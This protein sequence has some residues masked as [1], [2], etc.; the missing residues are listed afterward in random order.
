MERENDC[1]ACESSDRGGRVTLR[2]KCH[3]KQPASGLAAGVERINDM[4]RAGK[5]DPDRL[6]A[7]VAESAEPEFLTTA[8]AAALARVTVPT[9]QKWIRA[10]IVPVGRIG[11]RYRIHRGDFIRFIKE[12]R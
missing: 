10:G 3:S 7:Y 2:P 12:G 9:L 4:V 5:V 8:E 11:C 6:A 1:P